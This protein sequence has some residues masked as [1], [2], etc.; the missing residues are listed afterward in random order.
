MEL[1]RSEQAAI[2]QKRNIRLVFGLFIGLLIGFTLFSNTLA[3]MSLPK[4]VLAMPSR[5]Q[6]VHTFTG[7]GKVKW[8]AETALSNNSGWR[9]E[10][11]LVKE[12]ELVQKGQTL[13]IYNKEAAEQQI[14]D[15]QAS[16]KK[17][18]LSQEE[19]KRNFIEA[20]QKADEQAIAAAK[21]ALGIS[22]VDLEV[23]ERRIQKLQHDL[24]A[25]GMLVAPFD[26]VVT[27]VG[28]T[29]GQLSGGAS[30]DVVIS[31]GSLGF[32]FEFLA[33][34]TMAAP[35][36]VG[37]SVKVRV[38]GSQTL[39]VEGRIEHIQNAVSSYQTGAPDG[40]ITNADV[41]MKL[42]RI[43]LKNQDIKGGEKAQVEL[44]KVTDDVLLV[45]NKAI[46]DDGGE[47]YVFGIEEKN[48]PLGNAFYIRK[49]LVTVID[50]N[51]SVSAVTEGLFEDG[52]IVTE[53]SEPLQ[54]G[55]KIRL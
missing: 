18:K 17:L 26:G 34:A 46:R 32:E 33:P 53:S 31:N 13:V 35:L 38:E 5:G 41:S 21:N 8:K 19:L 54:A 1:Q 36:E 28:A 23:Q 16:L 52:K 25:N 49:Q 42:V 12:G 6:L 24:K 37:E 50:S 29:E 2:G 15:E 45:P 40:K 7:S 9:V 55:D 27:K 43:T 30:S 22:E 10:K 48:G 3:T 51:E 47:K 44:T 39:Q 20:S 4:V 14:F 11:V